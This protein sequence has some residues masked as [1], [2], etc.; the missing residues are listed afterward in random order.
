MD[1]YSAFRS[2]DY[3]LL[4]AGLFLSNFGMQMLSVA[5]SWD[6]Y[7]QTQSALV[8]GNVGF[9]QV[10]PFL[11]FALFAGHVADRYDRRRTMVLDAASVAGGICASAGRPPVRCRHLLLPVP[12]GVRA[13]LPV[14]RAASAPAAHRVRRKR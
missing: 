14:A 1:A 10:A 11:L 7:L 4:L 12:D 2:R 8:L 9:V 5:V 3:R 13:G 6:L